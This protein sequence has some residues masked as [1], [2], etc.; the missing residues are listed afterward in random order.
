MIYFMCRNIS[1]IFSPANTFFF[2]LRFSER[3]R[4]TGTR[5]KSKAGWNRNGDGLVGRLF[6]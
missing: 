3:V 4:G 6:V 2:R 5:V 1:V